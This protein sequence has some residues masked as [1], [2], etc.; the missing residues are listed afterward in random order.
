MYISVDRDKGRFLHKS[1]HFNVVCN[2]DW[3]EGPIDHLEVCEFTS[4]MFLQG[5][6]EAELRKLYQNVTGEDR[7]PYM[8]AQLKG[9]LI[10][11]ADRMPPNV[12]N[13]FELEVQ[14][15][16]I[17][18]KHGEGYRNRPRYQFVENAKVPHLVTEGLFGERVHVQITP[19]DAAV[20]AR[21]RAPRA[22]APAPATV[23][24]V[25]T[26]RPYAPRTAARKGGVREIVWQVADSMW[27]AAGKPIDK[28]QVLALRKLMMEKLDVEHGVKRTSSSNELGNWQKDRVK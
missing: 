2:L 11:L 4:H 24:P 6:T 19:E 28:T 23:T 15:Q 25:T 21:T 5:W 17:S 3:I 27:E 18:I 20:A 10:E 7:V 13:T 16:F 22:P 8:G 1:P 26:A 12:V 9:V 14:A